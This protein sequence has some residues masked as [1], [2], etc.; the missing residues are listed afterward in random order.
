MT[1]ASVTCLRGHI[2][3]SSV[4]LCAE[5]SLSLH[6]L[7]PHG[8]MW[9][10]N[11]RPIDQQTFF[12]AR[13]LATETALLT[14]EISPATHRVAFSANAK[15]HMHANGNDIRSFDSTIGSVNAGSD[16][17]FR[18]RRQPG[19]AQHGSDPLIAERRL[20]WEYS[21]GQDCR[22]AFHQQGKH[23]C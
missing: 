19:A 5:L 13:S 20:G 4:Q 2:P 17:R 6:H 12:P 16:T 21:A 18:L 8:F 15:S 22:P 14:S 1:C 9:T 7:T 23:R 10:G 11:H 3:E